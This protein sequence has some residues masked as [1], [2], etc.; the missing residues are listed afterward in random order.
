MGRGVPA[1]AL[2]GQLRAAVRAY[3]AQDLPP[4][5]LLGYLDGVVRG[6]ADDTLVTCV[7][8]VYDPVDET[9]TVANAGH[10]PPLVV[11]PTGTRRLEA[12][13]VVLGA[14]ASSYDQVEVPF[15]ADSLLAL[16]TDGLV[17]RR[18]ADIDA[19]IDALAALLAGRDDA[20]PV[21][22]ADAATLARDAP[23]V[24]D[25][26]VMLVRPNIEQ[27]PRVARL[28]IVPHASRVRDIRRF[29]ASTLREWG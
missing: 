21:L 29:A 7:Y 6:I 17:E 26:A 9:L 23:D 10:L 13:G 18:C 27:R 1:A 28:D 8:G 24:D 11:T 2:M 16:Y 25:I 4:G 15:G 14:G 22:C 20:L 12:Q 3:A 5:E 19:R